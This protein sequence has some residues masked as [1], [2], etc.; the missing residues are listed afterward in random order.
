[1]STNPAGAQGANEFSG[2]TVEEATAE[3]LRIMGLRAEDASV[4]IVHR[5]S[6]GLFGIGSELAVV[7]IRRAGER[8]AAPAPAAPG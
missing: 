7:R 3:G 1:M 5:G 8:A 4:E 2:K 6:R